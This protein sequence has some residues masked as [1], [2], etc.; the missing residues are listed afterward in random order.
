MKR[1]KTI[2]LSGTFLFSVLSTQAQVAD[3]ASFRVSGEV[4]NPGKF[5]IH[6]INALPRTTV[7][8]KD[9]EGKEHTYEGTLLS[10]VLERAGVS[11][12]KEL[13][14]KNLVKY[15]LIKARDGYEVVFSLPE[16]DPEFT[17]QSILIATRVDGKTLPPG[18]GLFRLVVPNDKK[19]ARWVRN[20]SAVRILISEE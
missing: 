18:E 5:S 16:V 1:I 15:I 11:F 8:A 4:S 3:T 12:G 2:I 7:K 19:H 17:D 20:V 14:G 10:A 6:D 13:R 9:K